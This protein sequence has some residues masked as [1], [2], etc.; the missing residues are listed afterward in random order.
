LKTFIFKQDNS[1]GDR[2]EMTINASTKKNALVFIREYIIA[3]TNSMKKSYN[4]QIDYVSERV[5]ERIQNNKKYIDDCPSY[6]KEP[7]GIAQEAEYL[8]TEKFLCTNGVC[9]SLKDF[10]ENGIVVLDY[11]GADAAKRT[12]IWTFDN[13]DY[14]LDEIEQKEAG[15]ISTTFVYCG[16]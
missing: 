12:Y 9:Y 4:E 14:I 6:G 15:V 1:F 10:E 11:F 3:S 2:L 13:E 8:Y 5:Q 16:R 7:R